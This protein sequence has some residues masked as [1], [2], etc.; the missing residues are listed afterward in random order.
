MP[1][2]RQEVFSKATQNTCAAGK[3][4]SARPNSQHVTTEVRVLKVPNAPTF[5]QDCSPPAP[6]EG[7]HVCGTQTQQRKHP[8]IAKGH[9]PKQVFRRPLNGAFGGR[10]W[11]RRRL[12]ARFDGVW[13][14]LCSCRDVGGGR[15]ARAT[16]R[17]DTSDH[18]RE[19]RQSRGRATRS[20]ADGTKT[21]RGHFRHTPRRALA[22][23]RLR[24]RPCP[25]LRP[26]A[27]C[28]QLSNAVKL[29]KNAFHLSKIF[30]I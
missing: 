19:E 30:Q 15:R 10:G 5:T 2:P 23:P 26:R 29:A 27:L 20:A 9:P 25:R 7:P 28:K 12:A 16:A 1:T 24:G 13:G 21:A 22:P 14:T 11:E 6:D 18:G 17:R 4:P 8:N 3:G